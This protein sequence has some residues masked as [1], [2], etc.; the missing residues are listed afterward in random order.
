MNPTITFNIGCVLHSVTKQ[1]K[2]ETIA[3]FAA[4]SKKNVTDYLMLLHRY[5]LAET[6]KNGWVFTAEGRKA[7]ENRLEGVV[8]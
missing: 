3:A 5:G 7:F 1:N 8:R 4:T 6:K 2:I